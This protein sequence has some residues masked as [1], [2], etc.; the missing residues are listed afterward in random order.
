MKE[1]FDKQVAAGV[2][3]PVT[4]ATDWVRLLVVVPKPNG[5]TRLCVDLQKL[6][7]YVKC[8]YYPNRSPSEVV[9]NIAPSSKFFTTL[10]AVKG[11]WQV[12]LEEKSQI[13]TTFITSYGR[14]KF[15]R[16]P[17]RLS[18]SQDE[19][20]ARGDAALQDID[21]V[22]KVVDDLLVH[23]RTPQENLKTTLNVLG[24]CRK[25]GITLN[26]EKFEFLQSSE[27]YVGYRV[28]CGGVKVDSKKLEAT[29]NFPAPTNITELRSFMGLANQL[30]DFQAN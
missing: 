1:E 21:R 30:V 7:Q 12:P 3:G 28:S 22:E 16:A 10:D 27:D 25:Q 5:G 29:Q 8:P 20:C 17:M 15:L 23:S 6:N 24:R 26:P 2:I 14:F 19:Y 9:S 18:S 11:Y 4:E 13:L